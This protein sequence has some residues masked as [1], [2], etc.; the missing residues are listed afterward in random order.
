M[1]EITMAASLIT[2]LTLALLQ[3]LNTQ[4]QYWLERRRVLE[5]IE[6]AKAIENWWDLY[7]T[8][9]TLAQLQSQHM[10]SNNINTSG[11]TIAIQR[12]TA[13]PTKGY[14]QQPAACL[15][16]IARFVVTV[17][18]PG[19]TGFVTGQGISY[20]TTTKTYTVQRM[21]FMP[22]HSDYLPKGF[23]DGCRYHPDWGNL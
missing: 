18:D 22:M 10:L 21:D 8:V 12:P 2:V 16:G 6:I 23:M 7:R 11:V 15:Y 19:F 3:S 20:D 4:Y 9:P 14:L 5:A 1:L 17:T 13:D